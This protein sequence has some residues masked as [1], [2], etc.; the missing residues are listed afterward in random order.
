MHFLG[1]VTSNLIFTL[2]SVPGETKN[3]FIL[4]QDFSKMVFTVLSCVKT[5]HFI[6]GIN[7]SFEKPI[8][9]K[10][11]CYELKYRGVID[12]IRGNLINGMTFDQ[13]YEKYHTD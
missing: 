4:I 11:G 7:F 8:I 10:F 6:D 1:W 13:F 12:T 3:V 5:D 2:L 9:M